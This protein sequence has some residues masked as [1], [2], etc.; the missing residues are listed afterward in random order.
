MSFL[1]KL[2]QTLN[3]AGEKANELANT[4][5]IKMDISKYN[6][7]ITNKYQK[8]GELVYKSEKE[9]T[10]IAEEITT[11]VN[12]VDLL[13]DE[14]AKLNQQLTE[15]GA[16]KEVTPAAPQQAVVSTTETVTVTETV[17]APGKI[18]SGCGKENEVTAVFCA[19][20]GN[21]LE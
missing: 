21:R 2:N 20:C 9:G 8:L 16:E 15:L 18:C 19:G 4:A 3:K 12:E 7:S 11:Y 1:D 6:T 5:K 13:F 17:S 14:I 10:E